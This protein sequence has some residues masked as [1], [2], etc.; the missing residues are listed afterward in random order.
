MFT[1]MFL[2]QIAENCNLQANDATATASSCIILLL[3]MFFLIHKL[4][5]VEENVIFIKLSD[6]SF[7]FK[8]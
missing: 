1:C 8:S 4:A 5:F 7:D 6:A 2:L 3:L